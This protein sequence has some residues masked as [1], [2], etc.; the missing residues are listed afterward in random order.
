M[1]I[2]DRRAALGDCRR[3]FVGWQK[4]LGLP[5]DDSGD[6]SSLNNSYADNGVGQCSKRV[7]DSRATKGTCAVE[8]RIRIY[9]EQELT[10]ENKRPAKARPT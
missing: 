4:R 2:K 9:P 5:L 1:L 10:F 3:L 7:R 6:R 8:S